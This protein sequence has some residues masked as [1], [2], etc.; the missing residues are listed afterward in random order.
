MSTSDTTDDTMQWVRRAETM[1]RALD[2]E[3]R[4][5]FGRLVDQMCD[6]AVADK[7]TVEQA[8]VLLG[9]AIGLVIGGS[10][11]VNDE[12]R[13]NEHIRAAIGSVHYF[14]ADA[15]IKRGFVPHRPRMH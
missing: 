6:L 13:I 7:L 10:L 9:S 3:T 12:T 8:V 5:R 2:P 14:T 11:D 15:R 4:E 1:F